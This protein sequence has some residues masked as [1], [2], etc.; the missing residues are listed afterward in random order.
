MVLKFIKHDKNMSKD[1]GNG[2]PQ[3]KNHV[4][5]FSNT[6]EKEQKQ[7]FIDFSNILKKNSFRDLNCLGK[8]GLTW[9]T[10]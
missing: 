6:Y 5:I 2:I 1:T 10:S 9:G 8:F 4:L 7:N 3:T